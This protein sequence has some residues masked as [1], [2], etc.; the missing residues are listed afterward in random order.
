M[1]EDDWKVSMNCTN[2][3]CYKI[4]YFSSFS[5]RRACG[6]PRDLWW[7]IWSFW[8]LRLTCFLGW[9]V[10]VLIPTLPLLTLLPTIHLLQITPHLPQQSQPHHLPPNPP[11][12]HHLRTAAPHQSHLHPPALPPSTPHPYGWHSWPSSW[13]PLLNH[14]CPSAIHS[15]VV[16]FSALLCQCIFSSSQSPCLKPLSHRP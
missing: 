9:Q 15:T 6:R 14:C 4:I 12:L 2:F 8:I 11:L 1:I 5:W 10:Q 16:S 3:K 13:Y 7:L